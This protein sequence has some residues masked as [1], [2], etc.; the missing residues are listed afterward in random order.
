MVADTQQSSAH[1]AHF[2]S[3]VYT[4]SAGGAHTC[5]LRPNGSP[6]C[7]GDE[8]NGWYPGKS[9]PPT[10]E[11]FVAIS[12]GTDHTCALRQDGTPVCWGAYER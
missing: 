6:V 8:R 1:A 10:Q 3:A 12:S 7:W 5:A 2:T 4:I 9:D 11:T